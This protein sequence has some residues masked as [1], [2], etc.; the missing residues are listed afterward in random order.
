MAG[1]I[2]GEFTGKEP[3]CELAIDISQINEP[4]K[5]PECCIYKVPDKLRKVNEE[6]YIPKL[7]SIGP[8][9][10]TLQQLT[11]IKQQ[12]LIYF[13]EFCL[14]TKKSP[15]DLESII[16]KEE[17]Q[18]LHYYSETFP[19][20][21]GKEFLKIILFDAIFIIELFLRNSES[22]KNDYILSNAWLESH[23]KQ[24]LILL[25]NQLPFKFLRKLYKFAIKEEKIIIT[26][27][28]ELACKFFFSGKH[29]IVKAKKVKHFTDLQR[30]FYCPTDSKPNPK[31]HTEHLRYTAT[32]LDETGLQFKPLVDIDLSKKSMLDIKFSKAKC[33]ESYPCFNLSWLFSCLPCLKSYCC[34]KSVQCFLK[35]PQL[36]IDDQTEPL[37]RNLMALEQCHYPS[38]TYICNYV[39][40]WDCLITTK[41]DVCLLVDKK[42]IVNRRG[43]SKAVTTLINTLGHQIIESESYYHDLYKQLNEHCDNSWNRLVASLTSVYFR[44]FWRGTATIA[45]IF[46]LGFTFGNFLRPFVMKH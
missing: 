13:K 12:K 22:K 39:L 41:K 29:Q 27:F 7:V 46:V 32:K 6:A 1:S 25:E 38:D 14:R 33:L 37:F 11:G 9:H 20:L 8:F 10:H 26:P 30:T 28:L 43:S 16:E 19:Q 36:V 35:V 18:I 24:D 15:K 3:K 45:G 42:V 2:A 5:W 44:D 40:L 17:K 23:I 34:F 31:E 21:D 4:A